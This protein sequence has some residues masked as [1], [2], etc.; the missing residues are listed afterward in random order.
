MHNLKTCKK[1]TIAIANLFTNNSL[2]SFS[3]FSKSLT[4]AFLSGAWLVD[5]E[6]KQILVKLPIQSEPIKTT[7]G[8]SGEKVEEDQD[9]FTESYSIDDLF[10]SPSSS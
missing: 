5:D 4:Q 9:F 10:S 6:G 3:E 2:N 8:G 7:G 1:L